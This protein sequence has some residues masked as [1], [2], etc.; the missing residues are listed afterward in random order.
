MGSPF[1]EKKFYNAQHLCI[2]LDFSTMLFVHNSTRSDRVHY[3]LDET[4]HQ[5]VPAVA[6]AHC[7]RFS[8]RWKNL[9]HFFENTKR[10]EV[11]D[12]LS[13]HMISEYALEKTDWS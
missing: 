11:T 2:Y 1:N 7:R 9:P 10:F 3:S 13:Q 4:K 5:L 6:K 8:D 12:D